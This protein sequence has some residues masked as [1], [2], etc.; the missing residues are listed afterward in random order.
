MKVLVIG[1]TLFIGRALVSA[2]EQPQDWHGVEAAEEGRRRRR[3][4]GGL[5]QDRREGDRERALES[6]CD[7]FLQ[8]PVD[9]RF[10]ESLL[11]AARG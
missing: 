7:Q 6:G 5:D 1:G 9:P 2:R 8:K 11:G 4:V 10:L 3:D